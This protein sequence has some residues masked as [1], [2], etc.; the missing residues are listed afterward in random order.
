VRLYDRVAPNG[1]EQD[2]QENR[3][4]RQAE[5]KQMERLSTIL[6]KKVDTAKMKMLNEQVA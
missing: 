4:E 2:L 6:A 1:Y 5:A 3:Y